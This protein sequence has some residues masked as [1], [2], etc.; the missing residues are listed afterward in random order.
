MA[1]H[2]TDYSDSPLFSFFFGCHFPSNLSAFCPF[3]KKNFVEDAQTR[4]HGSINLM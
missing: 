3:F 2:L 4:F 1:R